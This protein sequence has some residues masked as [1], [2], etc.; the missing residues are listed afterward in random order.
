[1]KIEVGQ[2]YRLRNGEIGYV[3]GKM[4]SDTAKHPFRMERAGGIAVSLTSDGRYYGGRET[5][6]SDIIEHL[7]D[8]DSFT[9][10][11]KPKL[12]LRE[13]AWYRRYDGQIV[14]PCTQNLMSSQRDRPWD[15][16]G[17]LYAHDGTNSIHQARLLEEVPDPTPKPV[18][19]PF[20]NAAEFAPH[21][22]RW[23]QRFYGDGCFKVVAYDETSVY[24]RD[25][26]SR[27]T[28]YFTNGFKFE[29]GTP[30]GVLENKE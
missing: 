9:W 20:A 23:I 27:Y 13:G 3:F 16:G 14:G 6:Q 26:E 30:F 29:D 19:R 24:T 28:T 25:G 21:R 7:P 2:W 12:Q 11:P 1:M 5:A 4:L 15:V 8:C 18:Y 22:D 17:F 10:V